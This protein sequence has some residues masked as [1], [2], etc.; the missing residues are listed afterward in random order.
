[1]YT[2]NDVSRRYGDTLLFEHVTFTINPGDRIG[3]VG[4]N[5]A[6]K[7]SLLRIL[8]G[9]DRPDTGSIG[10]QPGATLGYLRQGFSD[11]PAGTLAD[12]LDVPTRGLLAA[13]CALEEATLAFGDAERDPDEVADIFQLA[14]DRFE[15]RG[16][17]A[18]L[19]ELDALLDRFGLADI[20][21]HRPLASLSGGQKTRAGLAAL[22]VTRPDVLVLDE[23]TNHLDADALDWLASYLRS[24]PG[25]MLIVSHDRAFLDGVATSILAIDDIAKSVTPYTGNYSDFIAAKQREE[26]D[27]EAAWERQQAEV[28]RINRDIRAAETKARSIESNTID[29]AVRKKAA[30][31]ARPAVVRKKKLER[32][33]DSADAAERPVRRWGLAMDLDAPE[34]GARDVLVMEKVHVALGG[35]PVLRGLDLHLRHGERV[36]LLGD[37]GSGKTTLMRVVT[38]ELTPDSGDVRLGSGVRVGYFAQEQQVLEPELTVLQQAGKAAAMLESE[39]RAEL[40]K[41]LFGGDTVHRR[42]ADLSYGERARLMLA[43]LVLK[44]TSLL[45]LD[46]PMNHL[47]IESREEFEQALAAFPGTVLMVLHDRYAVGRLAGRVV[48]LKQGVLAERFDLERSCSGVGLTRYAT[49][50]HALGCSS[51][52][53]VF[54]V[55][56]TMGYVACSR[57]HRYW[58]AV[59]SN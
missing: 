10:A 47:D 42:I 46:E 27:A 22:L 44:Q 30:K 34:G 7:S 19:A 26:A 33:L 48:E 14:S 15:A 50:P 5:G 18:A 45:L 13:Q 43:L 54:V 6:G 38:G 56:L 32:M 20:P 3:L 28:A 40:H 16:G 52:A 9:E 58:R 57:R 39:L 55:G 25:A 4:P 8:T 29:Y 12:L 23:P 31:I 24:W 37:N 41:F 59:R 1:M 49:Y 2:V 21:H 35:H 53:F 11:I 51:G 36:A 17:Y